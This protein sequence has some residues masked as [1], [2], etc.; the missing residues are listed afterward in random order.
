[1]LITL[2]LRKEIPLRKET[3]LREGIQVMKGIQGE[4][5]AGNHDSR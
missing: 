1:M 3:L 2:S 5:V 4:S